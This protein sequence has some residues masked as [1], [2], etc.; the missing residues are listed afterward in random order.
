MSM[1]RHPNSE[2]KYYWIQTRN[3]GDF[4]S[5]EELDA[6]SDWILKYPK[7]LEIHKNKRKK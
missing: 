7:E 2:G 6:V 1:G 3:T 5:D 4:V